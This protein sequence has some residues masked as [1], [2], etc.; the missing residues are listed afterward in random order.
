MMTSCWN[1][2]ATS[3]I[4]HVRFYVCCPNSIPTALRGPCSSRLYFGTELISYDIPY[5]M[6]LASGA[7]SNSRRRA[8][9]RNVEILLIYLFY[10]AGQGHHNSICQLLWALLPNPPCQL[11]LWEETGVPGEN[12][13]LSAER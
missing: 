11:S 5:F 6:I 3:L 1:R 12:P 4:K 8:F 10:L 7:A 9:A 2:I 13:R